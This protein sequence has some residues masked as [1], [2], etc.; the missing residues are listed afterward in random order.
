LSTLLFVYQRWYYVQ[1]TMSVA[2]G[3]WADLLVAAVAVAAA[4]DVVVETLAD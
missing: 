4:A 1:W 3:V 2:N